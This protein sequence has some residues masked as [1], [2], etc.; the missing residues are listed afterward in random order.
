M[1]KNRI[2]QFLPFFILSF[3]LSS[4]VSS[5]QEE[6]FAGF[7]TAIGGT[8]F[9]YHSPY[10][11]NDPCLLS[12]ANKNFPAI[13]WKTEKIPLSYSK[14]NI[15][16][17]WL[18]GI[19]VLPESQEFELYVNGNYLLTFAN[20]THHENDIWKIAGANGAEIVFNRAV[21]DK[22]SDEMGYA[23]LTLPTKMVVKGEAVKIK[24]DGVDHQSN[25]W[26]MTFKI[27]LK[28]EFSVA[29]IKAVEK[30]N[31][32]QYHLIRFE[33]VHLGQ[34][35][36]ATLIV[37]EKSKVFHL[38]TGLNEFDFY[39]PKV[40]E[41][42][43]MKAKVMIDDQVSEKQLIIE[44][45]KE[46]TIYLVQHSH[47][48]IGYTRAQSEILAEHL[49][50]IDDALDYCD[51]TDDYPD[52]AKFRWT[53]EAAWAVRE[54]LKSRPESQVNRLLQRINEGR[55]EVTAMF[56]NYSE[57]ADET[58][59][60]M[61]TQTLKLF[62]SH[63]IEVSTAMQNDINGIAWCLI[64]YFHETGVKYVSM[65][66][67]GHRARIP[68]NKPTAFWWESPSGNKLLA[69]R[70]EHYM[71]GNT[72]GLTSED[73]DVL[74]KNLSNYLTELEGKN[75]PFDR[76][77]LQF[78]GYI[79]DNSP[80]S[81]KACDVVKAWNGKYEWPKLKLAVAREFMQYLEENDSVQLE[82]R[83]VAWPDW[84]T[85]GFGTAMNETK[86]ARVTQ[87]NMIANMGLLSMAQAS[88]SKI[89][90]GLIREINQCYDNLLFYDEH[91][92]GAAESISEPL[93]EN[94]VNQ[95]QQKSSY[96][97]AANQQSNLLLEKAM[98]LMEPYIKKTKEASITIFNTLNWSRSGVVEVFIDHDVLPID[99]SYQITDQQ[100]NKI[101]AQIIKSR[102][103]G[104]YWALWV[105]DVP[106]MGYTTC[107][108]L[109]EDTT[110]SP[111]KQQLE[112]TNTFEN[113]YYK[114]KIDSNTIGVVSLIDKETNNE[115]I[116]AN[117]E[118]HLGSL[119]YET[120]DNRTDLE[121]LTHMN[122]DTVYKPLKKELTLLSDCR[123]T[124][125]KQGEIWT[126]VFFHGMLPQCANSN[127][128]TMEL[129]LYHH[130]K[131]I[132]L[133]YNMTKLA[134]TDPE[135]IYIAFPFSNDDQGHLAFEA[136]GGVVYPGKNQLEGT[137]SD[138][139]TI[140]N[141]AAVRSDHA[142][143]VFCSNE[144]PL[145]QFGDINTG[146]YYYKHE[147]KTSHVFSW[148]LNNYWTTNFKASQEGEINW[149]Y[150]ITSSVDTSLT[151]AT[152]FGVENR[153]PM[154]GRANFGNADNDIS[155]S[156]SIIDLHAQENILLVSARPAA[157]GKGILL[158]FRETE[159]K[160]AK[161]DNSKLLQNP[162]ITS[163]TEVNVLGEKI[164]E[165]EGP[166]LFA[167]N[168][169]KF[170]LLELHHR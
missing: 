103:E 32:Q 156:T 114:V 30:I 96:V 3:M 123:I 23:V 127:G 85:D 89:P 126:S 121:R 148:V 153:V 168:E 14:K 125:V 155:L 158:H 130:T 65:G 151:F 22:H 48:D 107:N 159:G 74:A 128:V 164:N 116:D 6:Y 2:S 131:K 118:Y 145:V 43:L 45:V 165:L 63:G 104:S 36:D 28:N 111:D 108:I 64:D 98:G 160:K 71:Q 133:L 83:Q 122:R 77:A 62:K 117:S 34:P 135:S 79:T 44:P 162:I 78:S 58:A 50:Y 1:N 76:V 69:Y 67:H 92:F 5:A 37:D 144:I 66:Q 124:H 110:L 154:M 169:T 80:P 157:D 60:A 29:Q 101:P 140:Q 149:K 136:Q 24:I 137:A 52:E 31:D 147:P 68:F 134:N 143:T 146:R 163:V 61:Q 42:T 88:G 7:E 49:R 138:W 150:Q 109:V 152:R 81:I 35:K 40:E 56:F 21:I 100:G 10:S 38:K 113:D 59:L 39:V 87:S 102:S 25:A 170:L 26:Y 18:Y 106:P 51:L 41:P 129:R 119:I 120:L 33:I 16:F 142:Q 20:P 9:S 91:T 54:Y 84:W 27:P 82:T 75:Y 115:L 46:W 167:P 55:I 17:I 112:N 47:T 86:T 139:N 90:V 141:F 93:S 105:S 132:E 57:I 97:W 166:V 11:H 73:K 70:S 94:S 99:K 53:C 12:R 72:L 13:E 161:L 8:N 15:S 19:D 95:W 4:L